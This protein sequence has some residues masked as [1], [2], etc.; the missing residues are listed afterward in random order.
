VVFNAFQARSGPHDPRQATYILDT[1]C[2]SHNASCYASLQALPGLTPAA[3]WSPDSRYLA[4]TLD[5]G[6][7]GIFEVSSSRIVRDIP[8]P[9]G[10]YDLAWSPDGLSIAYM[11]MSGPGFGL[12]SVGTWELTPI[13][14]SESEENTHVVFWLTIPAAP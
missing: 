10:A 2:L 6:N 12:L 9:G 1:R 11:S 4:V 8:V 5:T 14:I 3:S 7:I 13:P